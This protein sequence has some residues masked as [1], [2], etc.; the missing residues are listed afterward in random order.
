[1][2]ESIWYVA[3]I[4]LGCLQGDV[5]W[6]LVENERGNCWDD[7]ARKFLYYGYIFAQRGLFTS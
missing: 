1:M 6:A 2:R 5:A 4:V 3:Y 7:T